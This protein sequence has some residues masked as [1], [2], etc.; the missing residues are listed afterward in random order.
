MYCEVKC[1]GCDYREGCGL[2]SCRAYENPQ[3]KWRL[4]K[5]NMATHHE[6]LE[7]VYKMTNPLKA[8]KRGTRGGGQEAGYSRGMVKAMKRAGAGD[9]I[10]KR[11]R[12]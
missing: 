8:S 7:S 5:C 3:A 6:Q 10:R 11:Q 12:G 1:K 4:G 2:G 9:C